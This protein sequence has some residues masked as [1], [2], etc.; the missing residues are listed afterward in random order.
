MTCRL[1][2]NKRG[3]LKRRSK[4]YVAK[5]EELAREMKMPWWLRD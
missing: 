3:M 5:H 1:F 2:L 4:A